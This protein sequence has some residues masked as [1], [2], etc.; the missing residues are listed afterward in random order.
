M[1]PVI[2]P[3]RLR[4]IRE[5]LPALAHG[6]YMNTG[7]AGPLPEAAADALQ[8]AFAE[9]VARGRIGAG[10]WD[11]VK[12]TAQAA[13]GE[14][15]R[16]LATD[17]DRLALLHHSTDGLNAAALGLRW[18]PGDV[19]VITD[20]EHA[21]VQLVAG[22]LRLRYGV[23]VRVARV[24][25]DC[26]GPA[27][28]AAGGA[29][30]PAKAATIVAAQMHG[31][32][33]RAV[34]LSHVSY[35]SGAVLP[36]RAIADVAHAAG[37]AV[38]VDGAQGAGALAVV[39]ADLGCDFY[40]VS[41]QK[42]LCGP[43][44]TGALWV[45]PGWEERLLPGVTGYGGI[46]GMDHL[47]GHFLPAP[48]ARRLEVGTTFGPGLA[49]WTAALRW[50]AGIGWEAVWARTYELAERCRLG[51]AGLAGVEVL[52]P[53]EHGG[54]VAFRVKGVSGE[55]GAAALVGRGFLVRSVP[56]WE[57]VRASLGFFL[58]EGEVDR[59]VGAVAEVA[60]LAG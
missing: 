48:G 40:T 14:L 35:A 11:Q 51:L 36:V 23:E 2:T 25:A 24:A 20:L 8:D 44:G 26:G 53:P 12:A 41:G 43:E 37:A 39:P 10:A 56:G 31:G 7:T 57:A 50:L 33:V 29:V 5:A 47:E 55:E 27:G 38:V 52:T 15:A 16:L 3:Q 28:A 34:F 32:F 22:M 4:A 19:L 58:E 30:D 60:G 18:R 54:L 1:P 42:W 21:A 17:E 13:R 59:L 46:S 9:E 45:A 6:T 49:G